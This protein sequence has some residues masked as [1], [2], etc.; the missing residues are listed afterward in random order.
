MYESIADEVAL[1]GYAVVPDFIFSHAV[2]EMRN[3]ARVLQASGDM[4]RAGIGQGSKF[5]LNSELRGDD[6]HWLDENV[7]DAYQHVYL[8]SLESLRQ[9]LNRSLALG[10]FE[11]EGHFAIYP[12]GAYYRKHLDQFQRDNRRTLTCILYLNEAWQAKDGGQLR[13]YLNGGDPADYLDVLPVGGT[14]VTFLS[15]RFWHEVLPAKR[16]RMSLTGWYKT[17]QNFI[18]FSHG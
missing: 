17:R 8:A 1:N 7:L 16:E 6:I 18:S 13:L 2:M 12:A 3:E 15:S 4:H 5:S 11:F 9:E 10:L 14:L